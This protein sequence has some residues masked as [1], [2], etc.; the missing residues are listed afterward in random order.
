MDRTPRETDWL[1]ALETA[2]A[3]RPAPPA[4]PFTEVL[5][6]GT[7][8]AGLYS[9][10]LVDD[11]GPHDQDEVYVIMHGFGTFVR[12]EETTT[13]EP[14]DL[15]FVPAGM[16]HRFV[17]FTDDLVVW[18]LFWGPTGGEAGGWRAPA[19]ASLARRLPGRP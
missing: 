12:G 3:N 10:R 1:I 14:G 18:V 6:H 19:R 9:P 17:N 15:L 4:R 5:R 7:M 2:Q 13:F 11:Q 16:T 8:R